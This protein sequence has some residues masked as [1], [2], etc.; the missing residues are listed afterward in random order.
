[1]LVQ[2]HHQ[3][4][5]IINLTQLPTNSE[6]SAD[7]DSSEPERGNTSLSSD[8]SNDE[9]SEPRL[10]DLNPADPGEFT[11]SSFQISPL[12]TTSLVSN[13]RDT[14]DTNAS[15]VLSAL[16]LD[17]ISPTP[18][19]ELTPAS[20]S[21]SLNNARQIYQSL[22]FSILN[23]SASKVANGSSS[24]GG[25][26][27]SRQDSSFNP[28]FLNISFTKNSDLGLGDTS[29]GFIDLTLITSEGTLIGSRT[30][31]LVSELSMLLRGF[32]SKLTSQRSLDPSLDS[33]EASR[34]Y[35]LF[36]EPL[37]DVISTEKITTLLVS[38]DRGLQAIPFS[39]LA[40]KGE[41]AVQNLSFSLT[42]SLSLTDLSVS[43][44]SSKMMIF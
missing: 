14:I 15:E 9:S 42:P 11:A 22:G 32:Y 16:G 2:K 30:E 34:L 39:A 21:Q 18:A 35:S 25:L 5:L 40:K 13:L 38:S 36:L 20:I 23:S 8:A 4:N 24:R 29:K 10:G 37:Q 28:A 31:L 41:F 19:S 17:E 3:E 1:M 12:D 7:S 43:F 6:S 26:L 44:A 27:S 33:S